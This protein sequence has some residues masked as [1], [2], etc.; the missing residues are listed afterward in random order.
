[1]DTA[2]LPGT[3]LMLPSGAILKRQV[4]SGEP[5]GRRRTHGVREN[6]RV[7]GPEAPAPPPLHGQRRPVRPGTKPEHGPLPVPQSAGPADRSGSRHLR[8]HHRPPRWKRLWGPR[9][10]GPD[11]RPP[12]RYVAGLFDNFP[13]DYADDAGVGVMGRPGGI[14]VRIVVS[15]DGWRPAI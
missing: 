11:R 14:R 2:Q 13:A 9:R 6:R 4:G 3:A 8:S 5:P 12:R 15:G 10:E 1:M 7:H